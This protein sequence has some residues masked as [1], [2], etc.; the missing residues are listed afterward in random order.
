L[1][2][3]FS[4]PLSLSISFSPHSFSPS[5][6][7]LCSVCFFLPLIFSFSL[8]ALSFNYSTPLCFSHASSNLTLIVQFLWRPNCMTNYL[9]FSSE[10]T[11]NSVSQ[12]AR[13][14]RH[15]KT[16]VFIW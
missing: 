6:C 9:N 8:I 3:T 5:P 15:T 4:I 2:L 16:F 13:K 1:F 10:R 12:C 7:F 14:L 11:E